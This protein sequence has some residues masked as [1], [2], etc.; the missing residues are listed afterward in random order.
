M[1]AL[2]H[3]SPM[4][5]STKAPYDMIIASPTTRYNPFADALKQRHPGVIVMNDPW[6]WMDGSARHTWYSYGS[7]IE[8]PKTVDRYQ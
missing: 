8:R 1:E 4:T 6:G 7:S 2:L 5:D 3:V